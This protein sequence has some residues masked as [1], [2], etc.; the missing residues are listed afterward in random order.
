MYL[1]HQPQDIQ[2]LLS[3]IVPYKFSL[4][5]SI[6]CVCL[7]LYAL[8]S[9]S[10][11]THTTP[12]PYLHRPSDLVDHVTSCSKSDWPEECHLLVEILEQYRELLADH[13]QAEVLQNLGLGKLLHTKSTC[14]SN[15]P[16]ISTD[17]CNKTY[18]VSSFR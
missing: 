4:Q 7:Q 11:E 15:F 12:H 2:K 3:R 1:S 5:L 16:L 18:S 8:S 13:T 17:S 10:Q 9:S 14:N 6:Y